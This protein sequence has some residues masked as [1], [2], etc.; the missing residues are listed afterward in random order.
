[1]FVGHKVRILDKVNK[2]WCPAIINKKGDQS[3][4]YIDQPPNGTTLRKNRSHIREMYVTP[5]K[6]D[7]CH[8]TTTISNP[9]P[10]IHH[11]HPVS[12]PQLLLHQTPLNTPR[13][14]RV[15]SPCAQMNPRITTVTNYT[16]Q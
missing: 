15:H 11:T 7:F 8:D 2:T 16:T 9:S 6:L 1:M 13:S 3:R 14:Q 5:R 12:E 10:T 4:S